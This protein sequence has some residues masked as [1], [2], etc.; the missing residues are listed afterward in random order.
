MK[1]NFKKIKFLL[2]LV[3]GFIFFSC[4]TEEDAIHQHN[5]DQK[6]SIEKMQFAELMEIATFSRAISRIP[7]K[8]KCQC[9]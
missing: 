9:N 2:L 7:K 1:Q 4:T 8:K 5:H 6:I 3:M